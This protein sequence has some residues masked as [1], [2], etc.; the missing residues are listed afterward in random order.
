MD[1]S[2]INQ[3]IASLILESNKLV[4]PEL[5]ALLR[6]HLPDGKERITFSTLLRYN[7]GILQKAIEQARDLTPEESALALKLFV[8][9][10]MKSVDSKTGFAIPGVGILKMDELKD[11]VL[12]DETASTPIRA[13]RTPRRVA[14]IDIA[15]DTEA[16]VVLSTEE[17][18]QMAKAK[19]NRL[20]DLQARLSKLNAAKETSIK[21]LRDEVQ[22]PAE[23]PAVSTKKTGKK[24]KV[25]VI[26]EQTRLVTE[27]TKEEESVDFAETTKEAIEVVL[28]LSKKTAQKVQE[29]QVEE[30]IIEDPKTEDAVPE[31]VA[32]SAFEE[33]DSK[34]VTE[35]PI[36]EVEAPVKNDLREMYPYDEDDE[37]QKSSKKLMI[38]LIVALAVCGLC[39]TAFVKSDQVEKIWKGSALDLWFWSLVEPVGAKI[40]KVIVVNPEQKTA[41]PAKTEA[42]AAPVKT[43]VA[44]QANDEMVFEEGM[45]YVIAGSYSS[46]ET[47]TK[48]LASFKQAP[49]LKLMSVEKGLVKY[50]VVAGKYDNKVE[51]QAHIKDWEGSWILFKPL[52]K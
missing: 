51:A 8:D 4:I 35:E 1:I 25:Q 34:D 33:S 29:K 39:I 21:H 52:K 41:A 11:I 7:D 31:P 49:G 46:K 15:E 47:A 10:V 44:P 38:W 5:G 13:G 26:L 48:G 50:V 27:D 37:P 18:V 20:D 12:L 45:Y 6:K 42:P 22:T 30:T 16:P 32:E 24:E 17:D 19:A 23:V 14:D 36:A 9:K 40:D 28:Y 43:E 3:C 2:L